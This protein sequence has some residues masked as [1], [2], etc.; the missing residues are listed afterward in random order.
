MNT[1]AEPPSNIA[2][3]G[4]EDAAKVQGLFDEILSDARLWDFANHGDAFVRRSIYRLLRACI[5]KQSGYSPLF[6]LGCE[7]E[8]TSF[9]CIILEFE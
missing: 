2:E 4:F 1:L 6:G 3:L 7:P 5:A 9:S 8:L